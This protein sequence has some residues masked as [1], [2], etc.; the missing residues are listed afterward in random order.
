MN[1]SDNLIY[2]QGWQAHL[3]GATCPYES[4][5]ANWVWWTEGYMDCAEYHQEEMITE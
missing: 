4:V 1:G 2:C 5:S 3:D